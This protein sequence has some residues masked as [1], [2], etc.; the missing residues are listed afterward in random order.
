MAADENLTDITPGE[1]FNAEQWTTLLAV[2]DR[3]L[4]L[5]LHSGKH[6]VRSVSKFI[7]VLALFIITNLCLFLF[8]L[9]RLFAYG[10]SHDELAWGIAGVLIGVLFTVYAG[11]RAYFV[12]L[13]DTAK[14]VYD[15]S[16]PLFQGICTRI[17]GH[18][19]ELYNAKLDTGGKKLEQIID[20]SSL[21]T[22]QFGKRCPRTIQRGI[23]FLLARIPVVGM[24]LE[25]KQVITD[26]DQERAGMMLHEKIDRYLHESLFEP[27]NMR[28]AFWLLPLN[29][30]ALIAFGTIMIG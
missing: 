16:T 2:A 14:F 29:I 5:L 7:G 22:E 1:N 4:Q 24:L 30:I 18:A 25:L 8:L 10:Y 23:S 12:V 26:G 11:Y 3:P 20:Y 27:T 17:V 28:F 13:V 9:Y 21:L 15:R 19:F 6:G